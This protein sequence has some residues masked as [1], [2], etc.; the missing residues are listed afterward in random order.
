MR[1][2]IDKTHFVQINC[3]HKIQTVFP[4]DRNFS[5][6]SGVP[7][8]FRLVIQR[9]L[10]LSK[11]IFCRL[12]LNQKKKEYLEMISS[13]VAD[14]NL[15]E[16]YKIRNQKTFKAVVEFLCSNIG[17]YVSSS[18]RIASADDISF[19]FFFRKPLAN[20]TKKNSGRNRINNPMD[21]AIQ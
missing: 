2:L 16:H 3:V 9:D 10:Y 18:R 7:F 5:F 1:F 13:S 6:Y 19:V 11:L 8:F 20:F 4:L 15:I 12:K 21:N 14:R 17:S